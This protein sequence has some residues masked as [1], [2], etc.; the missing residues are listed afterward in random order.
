MIK[1]TMSN[2]GT[3]RNAAGKLLGKFNFCTGE[4]VLGGVIETLHA[5]SM[6]HT[7]YLVAAR[8]K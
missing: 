4:L 8:F 2:T 3:I 1:H 6:E 7:M 5:E